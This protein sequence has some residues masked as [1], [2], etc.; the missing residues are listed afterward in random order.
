MGQVL[1]ALRCHTKVSDLGGDSARG[2]V[3]R[4]AAAQ[5]W[6]A[7]P[8]HLSRVG[9]CSATCSRCPCFRLLR[10]ME[11]SVIGLRMEVAAVCAGAGAFR[12]CCASL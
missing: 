6:M 1:T 7:A 10:W 9:V 8:V 12:F 2:A 11:K 5:L 3:L 4:A